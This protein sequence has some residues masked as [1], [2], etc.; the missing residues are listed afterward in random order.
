MPGIFAFVF[1]GAAVLLVGTLAGS[2]QIVQ[3]LYWVNAIFTYAASVAVFP[4][5]A[6]LIL[7]A[8]R[9]GWRGWRLY[10]AAVLCAGL[11][12]FAAAFSEPYATVQLG[13][14]VLALVLVFVLRHGS[15]NAVR[16]MLIATLVGTMLAIIVIML[17]PGNAVRQTNFER[18]PVPVAAVAA[19]EHGAAFLV[20]S[21]LS[22]SPVGALATLAT[23]ALFGFL[24]IPAVRV[25]RRQLRIGI[26]LAF[27]AGYLLICAFMFI[28]FFA[29]SRPPPARA[30]IIPQA[31]W[32]ITLGAIGLQAGWYVRK[33]RQANRALVRIAGI[34]ALAVVII[35][36]FLLA[37]NAAGLSEPMTTYAREWEARDLLAR[38]AAANGETQVVLPAY[39]M[40]LGA[41]VGLESLSADPN[42]WINVC[43]AVYYG[44]ES[45]VVVSPG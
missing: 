19:L 33:G 35:A 4:L 14:C 11:A 10:G 16:V 23:G 1:G 31:V 43:A 22:F 45:V 37:I 20:A 7:A 41:R 25:S 15:S 44:V 18:S 3:S 27:I 42:F 17:A 5:I 9:H 24:L 28:G 26:I 6:A 40:D 13:I 29:S 32:I 12:F 8:A 36:P 34:A 30:Y 21:T 39:T 2:P 38:Q